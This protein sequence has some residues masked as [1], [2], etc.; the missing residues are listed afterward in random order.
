MI[1]PIRFDDDSIIYVEATR[2]DNGEDELVGG[3]TFGD[4]ASLTRPIEKIAATM[5]E[6][7][8]RVSPTKASVEFGIEVGYEAGQLTALWVKGGGKGNLKVTLE[9]ERRNGVDSPESI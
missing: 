2:V 1:V 8:R 4:V 5:V 9:W 6:T 7:L 3:L